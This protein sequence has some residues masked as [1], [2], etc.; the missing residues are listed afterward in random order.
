MFLKNDKGEEV[1]QYSVFER[2][3]ADKLTFLDWKL[4]FL[5][6]PEDFAFIHDTGIIKEEAPMIEVS[7]ADDFVR[8]RLG[9]KR[10]TVY[11]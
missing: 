4:C 1:E 6:D 8:K 10:R 11:T 9:K 3:L 5:L 7:E 2:R